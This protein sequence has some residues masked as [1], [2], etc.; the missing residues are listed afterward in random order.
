M[1]FANFTTH[2]MVGVEA[3][4]D[5]PDS[6]LEASYQGMPSCITAVEAHLI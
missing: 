1:R 6:P 3:D 2:L 4:M 5:L